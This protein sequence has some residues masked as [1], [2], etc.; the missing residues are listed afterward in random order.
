MPFGKGFGID[1]AQVYSDEIAN[2]T[3]IEELFIDR[4]QL[5]IPNITRIKVD[6][7][8]GKIDVLVKN[9]MTKYVALS[10]FGEGANKIFRILLLLALHKGKR[11]MIDEIDAG[12]HYSRFKQFWKIILKIA[13]EDQTQIIATTHNEECIQFFAEALEELADEETSC[14]D[15]KD[16]ARVIIVEN[17]KTLKVNVY[18]FEVFNPAIEN[19][20]EIRG[21][22]RL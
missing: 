1:L 11:L 20:V 17:I 5:F 12:I 10:Q 18:D 16:D 9:G 19:G 2:D 22:S 6:T 15:C 3:D 7:K 13:K 8:Q 4:M 14:K 21:G